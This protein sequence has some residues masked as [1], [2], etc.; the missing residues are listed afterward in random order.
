M[1]RQN[2]ETIYVHVTL[3]ARLRLITYSLS[4]ITLSI[5]SAVHILLTK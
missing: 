5:S 3:K 2:L 4:S 1:H